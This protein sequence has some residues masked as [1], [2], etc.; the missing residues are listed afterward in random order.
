MM[1]DARLLTAL[2][3]GQNNQFYDVQDSDIGQHCAYDS[4]GF[5]DCY[6]SIVKSTTDPGQDS[7]MLHI[8]AASAAL[9]V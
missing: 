7:E 4:R 2:E 1:L 9:S 3:I 6:D 5:H 8:Y